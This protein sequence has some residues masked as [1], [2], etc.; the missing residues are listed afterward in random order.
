MYG[1]I[2]LLKIPAIALYLF[3]RTKKRIYIRQPMGVLK[4]NYLIGLY[5]LIN[6]DYIFSPA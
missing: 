3:P 4:K 2:L 6:I 1:D 5:E